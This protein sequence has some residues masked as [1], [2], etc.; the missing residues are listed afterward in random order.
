MNVVWLIWWGIGFWCG[1]FSTLVMIRKF[2]RESNQEQE[3]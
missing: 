1:I 3:E 2:W